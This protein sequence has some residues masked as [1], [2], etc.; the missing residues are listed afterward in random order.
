VSGVGKVRVIRGRMISCPKTGEMIQPGT[1]LDADHPAAI[2]FRTRVRPVGGALEFSPEP[3]SDEAIDEP[4]A[5]SKAS[6]KKRT[7]KRS[8]DAV[9]VE[10]E[11]EPETGGDW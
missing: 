11:P 10:A 8:S 9:D 5:P 7:W 6:K 3:V 2:K 1:I 4:R